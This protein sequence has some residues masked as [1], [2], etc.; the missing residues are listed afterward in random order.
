MESS[1]FQQQDGH[2]LFASRIK[3]VSSSLRT[4]LE[5]RVFKD[6]FEEELSATFPNY[7]DSLDELDRDMSRSDYKVI[8]AGD[9]CSGKTTLINALIGDEIFDTPMYISTHVT[10]TIS[11]HGDR[12]IFIHKEND[13]EPKRKHFTDSKALFLRLQKISEDLDQINCLLISAIDVHVPLSNVKRAV[14][15]V[16]TPSTNENNRVSELI[17]DVTQL[18]PD[19]LAVVFLID[20][21]RAGGFEG[22]LPTLLENVLMKIGELEWFEAS[23]AIFMTTKWDEIQELS[24]S[25]SDGMQ[26]RSETEKTWSAVTTN[27]EKEWPLIVKENIFR[28]SL[29]D[30]STQNTELSDEFRR[31][32]D[33]LHR[34]IDVNLERRYYK[35]LKFLEKLLTQIESCMLAKINRDQDPQSRTAALQNIQKKI[36][37]EKERLRECVK[38]KLEKI[39]N[40]LYTY[41][42]SKAGQNEILKSF[43]TSLVKAPFGIFRDSLLKTIVSGIR[44]WCTGPNV[45]RIIKD[46]DH[47]IEIAVTEIDDD[48]RNLECDITGVSIRKFIRTDDSEMKLGVVFS[49]LAPKQTR[50]SLWKLIPTTMILKNDY[51]LAKAIDHLYVQCLKILTK[52][53]IEAAFEH[54]IGFQYDRKI[55]KLFKSFEQNVC[56]GEKMIMNKSVSAH[57]LERKGYLGL[58]QKNIACIRLLKQDFYQD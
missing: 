1:R 20:V 16:D 56:G 41:I 8:V 46:I 42:N 45:S 18:M 10:F 49:S 58:L 34:S 17:Q 23:S 31:F 12:N 52:S 48:F 25:S 5:D 11:H 6:V 32:L 27:L 28:V 19:A 57:D 55:S 43:D 47:D 4:I 29:S 15:L 33:L 21:S 7:I 26:E 3:E 30:L 24:K 53:D 2:E 35:H 54:S 22:I 44:N 40:D 38:S 50:D 36:S 39:S 13:T 37:K 14:A 51:I 9:N